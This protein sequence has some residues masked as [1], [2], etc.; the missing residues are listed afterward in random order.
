MYLCGMF[1][2]KFTDHEGR[3]ITIRIRGAAIAADG[4]GEYQKN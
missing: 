2:L 4:V 3:S 1:S